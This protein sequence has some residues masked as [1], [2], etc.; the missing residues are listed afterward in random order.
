MRSTW[1]AFL[2]SFSLVG[3]AAQA[4]I[5]EFDIPGFAGSSSSTV[6]IDSFTY[7]G[8]N[9]TVKNVSL[10]VVGTVDDLGLLTCEA[11]P[12]E[13]PDTT[14]WQMDWSG[15]ARKS[16]DPENDLWFGGAYSYYHETGPFDETSDLTN[17]RGFSTLS[18][19][20]T[21]E[22]TF[23]FWAG[24]WIGVCHLIEPPVGTVTSVTVLIDVSYPVPVGSTTWGHVKG[25]FGDPGD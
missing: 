6:R 3:P 16:C 22:V 23:R 8:D 20:D 4:E 12:G 17:N 1:A 10:R 11:P 13:P 9:A 18:E 2:L 5:L 25:T 24:D 15:S 7:H 14:S 19:G 21:I